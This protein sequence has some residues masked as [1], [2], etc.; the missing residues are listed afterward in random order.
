[1]EELLTALHCACPSPISELGAWIRSYRERSRE[2]PLHDAVHGGLVA[3]TIGLAFVA[4]YQA[5]LRRL[6]P[7]LPPGA[8]VALAA[9]ERA[10]GH[11]KA[12]ETRLEDGHLR[13]EKRYVTLGKHAERILVVA[14]RQREQRELVV[15]EVEA[16]APGV[17]ISE[18]PPAPFVP[19]VP[20]AELRLDVRVEPA[21][22][23][24]GDGYSHYLK[25]FRTVEDIFV[26]LALLAHGAALARGTHAA[27]SLRER[28]SADFVALA[29]LSSLDPLAP[30]VHVA[31]GGLL[32]SAA[33]TLS[34]LGAHLRSAGHPRT[35]DWT[36]DLALLSVASSVRQ[37]R[38]ARAWEAF[39]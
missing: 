38:L 16:Q 9:T 21:A 4:G 35:E 32:P 14:R 30:S 29:Q 1:M 12:M 36:R 26:T 8:L 6:T 19:D 3:G 5:A 7:H 37:Q 24:P 39:D 18:L 13:G 31:L 11:P 10:G 34:G 2:S 33:A 28:I 17:Q 22:I 25:P 15:V 23:L 27:R 20:H